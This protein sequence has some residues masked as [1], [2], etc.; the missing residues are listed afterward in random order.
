[1]R[2]E[3]DLAQRKKYLLEYVYNEYSYEIERKYLVENKALGYYTILGI[4]F[5]A[6]IASFIYIIS[7]DYVIGLSLNGFLNAICIPMSIIYVFFMLLIV[8]LLKRA[9]RPK[10]TEH[11]TIEEFWNKLQEHEDNL[12]YDSIYENLKKCLDFNREE[13]KKIVKCLQLTDFL[14]VHLIVFNIFL[15]LKIIF[16]ILLER[17]VLYV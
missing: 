11:Y 1:M 5:A 3:A 13:N 17:G 9:F 16:S 7:N 10:D 14:M 2:K 4:S 12:V 6:F 15:T 8:F